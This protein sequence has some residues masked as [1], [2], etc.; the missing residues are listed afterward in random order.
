M[1]IIEQTPQ[2]RQDFFSSIWKR[3]TW[4]N[5]AYLFLSFPLGLIYFVLL[6]I[7]IS[8]GFGLLIT[9]IGI[10]ILMAVLIMV[11]WLARF[12][13]AFTSTMLGFHISPERCQPESRGFW[14]RF[15]EILRSP[16]TWKG[17]F[18][19][20]LRFPLGIFSFS[21]TIGL[22]SASFG[23][24]SVPFLYRYPWFEMDWPGNYFWVIDTVPETLIIAL[25]GIILLFTSLYI[26]NLLAYVYGKLAQA[27]LS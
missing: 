12:E 24:I 11:H 21:L 14:N 7:G 2:T 15:R 16:L 4:L 23:L 25:I 22:L 6:I 13:A 20:F 26:L 27:F 5:V 18:F 10:F 3:Q 8:L 17:L 9:V 19:L 1:K